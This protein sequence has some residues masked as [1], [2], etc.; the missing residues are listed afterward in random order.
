MVWTSIMATPIRS[1]LEI[2]SDFSN[3]EL[4]QEN[5]YIIENIAKMRS[6]FKTVPDYQLLLSAQNLVNLTRNLIMQEVY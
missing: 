1:R 3:V 4:G 6:R 2:T 5:C